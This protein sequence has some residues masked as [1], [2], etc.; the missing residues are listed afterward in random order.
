MDKWELA[1]DDYVNGMKYKDIAEKH[2]VSVNTVKSWKSRK[3][4]AL[5][6]VA[7]KKVATKEKRLHTKKEVQQPKLKETERAIEE[8]QENDYL[9]E[10]QKLFCIYY[11]QYNN[12]TKAYQEAYEVD[13]STAHSIGY[14][15]LARDGIRAEIKRIKAARAADWLIN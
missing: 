7:H 2:G 6:K 11:S 10:K 12:A 15:M 14:R 8:V 1:Y 5:D 13:Y 4:N 3:W 9:S